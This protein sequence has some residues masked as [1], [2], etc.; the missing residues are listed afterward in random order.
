MTACMKQCVFEQCTHFI[1]ASEIDPVLPSSVLICSVYPADL[2]GFRPY[3]ISVKK[4][5]DDTLAFTPSDEIWK[6]ENYLQ[7]QAF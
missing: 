3:K 4:I 1:W 5:T 2:S 6:M 7:L